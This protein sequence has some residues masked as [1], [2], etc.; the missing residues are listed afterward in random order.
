MKIFILRTIFIQLISYELIQTKFS[1]NV[2][3]PT[4]TF[5][6]QIVDKQFSLNNSMSFILLKHPNKPFNLPNKQKI[7]FRRKTHNLKIHHLVWFGNLY[8]IT[9]KIYKLCVYRALEVN[10]TM[11]KR[12]WRKNVYLLIVCLLELFELKLKSKVFMRGWLTYTSSWF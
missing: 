5:E 2:Q 3:S 12:F 7:Q 10:K 1:W 8:F 4:D 11:M 9:N 6:I